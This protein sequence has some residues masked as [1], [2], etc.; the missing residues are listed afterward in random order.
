MALSPVPTNNAAAQNSLAQ[1]AVDN[2][3][4][5]ALAI[6]SVVLAIVSVL[7]ALAVAFGALHP[8]IILAS[9]VGMIIAGVVGSIAL[10]RCIK[11]PIHE[12][13]LKVIKKEYPRVIHTFIVRKQVTIQELRSVLNWIQSNYTSTLSDS[14]QVKVESFG[15]EKIKKGSLGLPIPDLDDVLI[16]NCPAYF[17]KGFVERGNLKYPY[18]KKMSP[19]AYWTRPLNFTTDPHTAFDGRTWLLAQVVSEDEYKDLCLSVKEDT[20][21]KVEELLSGI[22]KRML[23]RL[24]LVSA[25][26]VFSENGDL[27]E[28]ICK[29]T[30]W[31]SRLIA[32][33]VNFPQLQIFKKVSILG[34]SLL[35][36][37]DLSGYSRFVAP[38]TQE[39]KVEYY[40]HDR[41]LATW[42]E[43]FYV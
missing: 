3:R 14:A 33:G 10:G 16:Q 37:Q 21:E 12:G 34:P 11:T 8:A 36:G 22:R 26:E 6:V 28:K 35:E 1:R 15:K 20:Q 29:D 38:A 32:H 13:F 27:R 17:I 24:A 19:E 23:S 5:H 41:G 30:G 9:V 31:F 40:D 7:T 42:E 43:F 18:E 39:N 25:G 2:L 4:T